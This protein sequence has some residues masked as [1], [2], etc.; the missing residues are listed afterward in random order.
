MSWGHEML[1]AV[2][3]F[4]GCPTATGPCVLLWMLAGGSRAALWPREAAPQGP[5]WPVWWLLWEG[6]KSKLKS[7]GHV[8]MQVFPNWSCPGR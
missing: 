5:Q 2:E 4:S 7:A 1:E 6:I 3:A 8:H